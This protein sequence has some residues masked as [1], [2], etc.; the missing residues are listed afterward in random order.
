MLWLLQLSERLVCPLMSG[1][2]AAAAGGRLALL[3]ER[4]SEDLAWR[5]SGLEALLL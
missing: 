3:V 1:A 2:L 5:L 4:V